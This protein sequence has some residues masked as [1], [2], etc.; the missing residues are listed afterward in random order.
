M[1]AGFEQCYR[2]LLRHREEIVAPDG[3]LQALGKA[4]PRLICRASNLYGKLL[5]ALA[6]NPRYA[7]DG[8]ERSVAIEALARPLLAAPRRPGLW[9]LLATERRSVEEG[10]VPFF[11]VAQVAGT[12]GIAP[13][14]F[15]PDFAA[16]LHRLGEDDLSRQTEIIRASLLRTAESELLQPL[17]RAV[18][19]IPTDLPSLTDAQLLAEARRLAAEIA[20]RAEV[21]ERCASWLS[22]DA[23]RPGVDGARGA[24]LYFYSGA[25]GIAFFLAA[26]DRVTGEHRYRELIEASCRPVRAFLDSPAFPQWVGREPLGAAMGLGSVVYALARIGAFLDEPAYLDLATRTARWILP[27][28]I[29]AD[30]GYDVLGGSAGAILGLL[31]LHGITGEAFALDAAVNCGRHLCANARPVS[32]QGV[33]WPTGQRGALLAGFAHGTAGIA[34]ALARLHAA[35]GGS[36]PSFLQTAR[37]AVAYEQ[38]IFSENAGN[39]PVV[40]SPDDPPREPLFLSTWCH[41]APGIG[42][43]RIGGLEALDDAPIRRDIALALKNVVSGGLS[44]ID[45]LCC[46]NLGRIEIAWTAAH[47]LRRPELGTVARAAASYVVGQ[48]ARTQGAYRLRTDEVENR[49]FEAG[50]F[51]G[52]SGIGYT[53]LRLIQPELPCPLLFV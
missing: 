8:F 27:E 9:A 26:L 2:F 28:R 1:L 49:F 50:F 15:A 12:L 16:A 3:P 42:L 45:H 21:N 36:E 19:A 13:D 31:T 30:T 47:A 38:S 48:A 17:A 53:L 14:L 11:T 52:V 43:G 22:P 37:G 24:P 29:L 51:R 32:G 4:D 34:H 44:T 5:R 39:W 33:A 41:G 6:E 7:R 25:P 20:A 46:G 35:T 18:A 10:D 40:V 23:L